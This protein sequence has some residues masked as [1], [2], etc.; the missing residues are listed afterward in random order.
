MAAFECGGWMAGESPQN[1][2]RC[3]TTGINPGHSPDGRNG[4]NA[5]RLQFNEDQF[6]PKPAWRTSHACPREGGRKWLR[7]QRAY[8]PGLEAGPGGGSIGRTRGG[9]EARSASK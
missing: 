4:S 1:A 8:E 3:A 7:D 5:R 9:R 2:H 6:K